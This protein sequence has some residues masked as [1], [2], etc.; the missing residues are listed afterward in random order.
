MAATN[1]T[2]AGPVR[3]QLERLIGIELHGWAM[4]PATPD[5]EALTLQVGERLLAAPVRRIERADVNAALGC[6]RRAAGFCLELPPEVWEAVASTGQG[7]VVLVNGRRTTQPAVWPV[8]PDEARWRLYLAGAGSPAERERRQAV[9][10]AHEHAAALWPPGEP[11]AGTLRAS[12]RPDLLISTG[13]RGLR[14]TGRATPPLDPHVVEWECGGQR[15]GAR[16]QAP[17]ADDPSLFEIE[18]PGRAWACADGSGRLALRCVV[19]G[20]AEPETIA[21]DHAAVLAAAEAALAATDAARRRD[22]GLLALDHLIAADLLQQLEPDR[23]AELAGIAADA[24]SGWPTAGAAPAGAVP[25]PPPSRLVGRLLRRRLPAA[26]SLRLL[27]ALRRRPA[28]QRLALKLETALTGRLGLFDAEF[29]AQQAASPDRPL[30]L[31]LLHYVVDGDARALSPMRLFDPTHYQDQLPGRAHPG[32]NRLLHYALHGRHEGLTPSTWFDPMFYRSHCAAARRAGADPLVHYHEHGWRQGRAPIPGFDRVGATRAPAIRRVARQLAAAAG[33]PLIAELAHGLPDSARWP[34]A[35]RP[36]W[37]GRA[38]LED[39]DHLDPARWLALR[40]RSGPA[41]IAVIVVAERDHQATLRC[42]WSVLASPAADVAEVIAVDDRGPEPVLGAAIGWLAEQKLL[43]AI[44]NERTL[45]TEASLRRAIAAAGERDVVLLDARAS[46][47]GPWLQRLKAHAD[48]DPQAATVAAFVCGPATSALSPA[49]QALDRLAAAANAGR[50]AEV[51]DARGG[52]VWVRRAALARFDA[53]APLPFAAGATDGWQAARA[54]GWRHLVA[55]DV[56]LASTA[57]RP[58]AP[59]AAGP[60]HA[61]QARI[62][63]ARLRHAGGGASFALIVHHGEAGD[64]ASRRAA[65]AAS[66]IADRG[67]V[68]LSLAPAG[69]GKVRIDSALLD[70]TDALRTLDGAVDGEL[71]EVLALLPIVEIQVHHLAGFVPGLAPALP[72]LALRLGA[73]L[74]L[75]LHD[76]HLLCPRR[77]LTGLDGRYCGEPD[78]AGCDRC[79]QQDDAG[80]AAGPIAGWRGRHEI[81]AR[82]ADVVQVPDADLL[83]RLRRHWPGLLVEVKDTAPQPGRGVRPP[84]L[85]HG[86]AR[87]VLVI[88]PLDPVAGEGVLL[89]AAAS[90]P[91]QNH[92]MRFTLLGEAR[93]P[94]ALQ[95]AG[96][97]LQPFDDGAPMP[98]QIRALDPDLVFIPSLWPTTDCDALDAAMRA[99]R[100]VAMF[101]LGAPARRARAAGVAPLLLPLALADRPGELVKRLRSG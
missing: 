40:P 61:A 69:D 71:G 89:A 57:P 2:A 34:Q 13:L 35:G 60:L 9:A 98:Q 41:A 22:L 11:P 82:G 19:D 97:D 32:I 31:P 45:G 17:D 79:L 1:D 26:V 64:V 62:E 83:P 14:L 59:P 92:A 51:A 76:Y 80:R 52:C 63:A 75:V 10:A 54:D 85:R 28:L 58:E 39:R 81:L 78:D 84:A 67:L 6:E 96:V 87:H 68:P 100:R 37:F 50:A 74:L 91:A 53:H 38:R 25:L 49:H 66:R 101:E 29:Y 3:L 44:V 33:P 24:G 70:D 47:H 23:A 27:T 86:P 42:L 46:V 99:G 5:A 12:R 4:D 56:L 36:P 65:R 73:R 48:A 90:R 95:K 55:T 88:G 93:D 7:A 8:P 30:R 94:G 18:L 21:L 72:T 77:T 43:T 20:V 15:V 16:V